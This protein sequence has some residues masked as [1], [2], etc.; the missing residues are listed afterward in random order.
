MYHA[1]TKHKTA[2]VAMLIEKQ[3]Y[4]KT[5]SITKHKKDHFKNF[6]KG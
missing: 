6:Y 1:S 5:R 3:R 4:F 2:G